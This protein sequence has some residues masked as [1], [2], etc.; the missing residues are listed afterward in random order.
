LQ[1][2]GYDIATQLLPVKPFWLA[3]DY[4]QNY[5]QKTKKLPYCHQYTKRFDD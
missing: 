1:H 5:Y 3:E 2:K 4:H